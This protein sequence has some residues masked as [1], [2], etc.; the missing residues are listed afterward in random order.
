MLCFCLSAPLETQP[1]PTT[2]LLYLTLHPALNCII[3]TAAKLVHFGVLCRV[4]EYLCILL[5]AVLIYIWLSYR[6]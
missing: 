6:G 3:L 2:L 1:L 5:W 4:V